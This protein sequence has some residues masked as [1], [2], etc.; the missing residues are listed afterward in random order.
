VVWEILKRVFFRHQSDT[1][2]VFAKADE[3]H[4]HGPNN[5]TGFYAETNSFYEI[6]DAQ[7]RFSKEMLSAE[8]C[9]AS[10]YQYM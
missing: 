4:F 8:G 7:R 6:Q 3:H 5:N 9:K 1:V 2:F 10:K